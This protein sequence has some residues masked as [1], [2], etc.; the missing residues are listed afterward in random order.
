MKTRLPRQKRNNRL[1][2]AMNFA[3]PTIT[4]SCEKGHFTNQVIRKRLSRL[5]QLQNIINKKIGCKHLP[6]RSRKP[7]LFVYLH[8]SS[9]FN[10]SSCNCVISFDNNS[11]PRNHANVLAACLIFL[12]T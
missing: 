12:R 1:D 2:L 7:V 3:I 9:C 4:S 8:V 10:F 5:W 11:I 6:R